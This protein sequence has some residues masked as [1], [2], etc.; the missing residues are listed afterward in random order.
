MIE[1]GKN[2]HRSGSVAKERCE[3]GCFAKN[4]R[5]LVR[6]ILPDISRV[7]PALGS[8]VWDTATA[9]VEAVAG[10]LR[11]HAGEPVQTHPARRG[12][13]SDEGQRFRAVH[14]LQKPERRTIRPAPLP[15]DRGTGSALGWINLT[16]CDSS[17]D[18]PRCFV[19]PPFTLR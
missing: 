11:E 10:H 3:A 19:L 7:Q 1:P 6:W 2:G 13:R 17:G 5:P 18:S 15:M 16:T 4:G 9:A 14:A 12:W 8:G